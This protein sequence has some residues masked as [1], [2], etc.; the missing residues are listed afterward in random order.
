MP[1]APSVP[2]VT[3]SGPV[4]ATKPAKSQVPVDGSVVD[5]RDFGDR[6]LVVDPRKVSGGTAPKLEAEK[7]YPVRTQEI[8][9]DERF[10]DYYLLDAL[11]GKWPGQKNPDAP[12]V[13]PLREPEVAKALYNQGKAQLRNEMKADLTL[14][15]KME[16]D[17]K[18]AVVRGRILDAKVRGEQE[19]VDRAFSEMHQNLTRL[20]AK[21]G[22]KDIP[23]LNARFKRGEPALQKEF[24]AIRKQYTVRWQ[25]GVDDA[26]RTADQAIAAEVQRYKKEHGG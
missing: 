19:A 3:A 8:L 22:A 14:V 23:E 11:L 2:P 9:K 18:F 7:H 5:L 20:A 13:N 10:K 17:E 6:A 15:Q 26:R 12:L 1:D 25:Q 16:A 4:D 21:V 24:D